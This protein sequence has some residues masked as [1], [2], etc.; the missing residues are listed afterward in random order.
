MSQNFIP[1]YDQVIFHCVD[2]LHFVYPVMADRHLGSF[3]F[4]AVTSNAAM[5]VCVRV[6]FFFF[7]IIYLF[8]V[9]LGLCC[10]GF[11]F[12]CRKQGLLLSYSAQASHCRGFFCCGA[13]ALVGGLR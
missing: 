12:S 7:L 3:H 8:L 10:V 9:V 2:I 11:L 6:I 5:N 1:F 4:L 13:Q